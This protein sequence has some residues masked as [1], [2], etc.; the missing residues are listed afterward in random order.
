LRKWEEK[1]GDSKKTCSSVVYVR[2]TGHW[3][4]F[5]KWEDSSF[6]WPSQKS[7]EQYLNTCFCLPG[8]LSR[9]SDWVVGR[10]SPTKCKKDYHCSWT[11][12]GRRATPR[13]VNTGAEHWNCSDEHTAVCLPH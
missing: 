3:T 4:Y 9:Y 1:Q 7:L 5:K 13:R 6:F 11:C 10:T 12:S 8:C 2:V